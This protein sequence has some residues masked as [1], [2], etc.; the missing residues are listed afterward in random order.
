MNISI[1]NALTI[2]IFVHRIIN[3][4]THGVRIAHSHERVALFSQI[5]FQLGSC[6]AEFVIRLRVSISISNAPTSTILVYRITNSHAHGVRIANSHE[7]V[8]LFSQIVFQL[9][10][11]SAVFVIY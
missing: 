3:P 8:A 6:S 9:D 1:S 7:R 4:H 11:C 2:N 5:V 10:S